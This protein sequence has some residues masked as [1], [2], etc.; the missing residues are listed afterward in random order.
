MEVCVCTLIWRETGQA[1]LRVLA[2]PLSVLLLVYLRP[3]L[4]F[5]LYPQLG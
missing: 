4:K 1:Q 3:L 2:L 5:R